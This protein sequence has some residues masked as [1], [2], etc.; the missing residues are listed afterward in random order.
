M[1]DVLD[2]PWDELL[3]RVHEA[4]AA[5]NERATRVLR[6]LLEHEAAGGDT[7]CVITRLACKPH[8]HPLRGG[9]R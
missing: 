1:P 2:M 5:G 3:E 9:A 7:D 6:H 8:V 4:A